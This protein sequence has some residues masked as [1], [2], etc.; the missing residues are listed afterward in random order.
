MAAPTRPTV[1]YNGFDI[2]AEVFG[3]DMRRGRSRELDQF[4]AGSGSVLVR[5]YDRNFDPP[6]FSVPAF[7][8][9]ESG[10]FLL[11]ENTD[12]ILLEQGSLASGSYGV[13]AIG[14]DIVVSDGAVDVFTGHVSDINYS[15]D[16]SG[17][18]QATLV[19]SDAL[20]A[21]G[22]CT[23]AAETYTVTDPLTG[24]VETLPGW[25][26][27]DGQ[28][29]GA[30]ILEILNRDDV[31]VAFGVGTIDTGSI[32]LQGDIVAA[33]TNVLQYMQKIAE[34]EQGK[35]WL[36]AD[37]NIQYRGRYSFPSA[38]PVADF[39]DND[40]NYSF[41]ETIGIM[42]GGELRAW[43]ATVTRAGGLPQTADSAVSPP[44][45][46]GP[47]TISISGVLLRDDVY[48]LS[49]AE[50]LAEK[51]SN[52][53]AVVST[54]RIYLHGLS[55]SDRATV[56]GVDIN[57]TVTLTWQPTGAGEIITQTLV[58][59]GV[60][61]SADYNGRTAIDLQ[62]VAYPE[63]NYFTLD[64]DSMDGGKVLGY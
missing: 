21:I 64:T 50:F 14:G 9:M 4:Q 11:L 8:L 26:T 7:L 34:T 31:N 41:N 46:L 56:A 59:E 39:D 49:L 13:M 37:G 60:S 40:T 1:T 33:G 19:L 48:A 20:G 12:Q 35:L 17:R 42:F 45:T 44:A 22:G 16:V 36:D 15:Y 23:F 28:F 32:P 54:L 61:Y 3:V 29:S 52:P 30:R 58:V 27:T 2:T 63:T 51:Y 6:W 57:D 24:D 38:T 62:L 53:E 18:T 55:T 10:D 47:S 43:S 5:N 25:E